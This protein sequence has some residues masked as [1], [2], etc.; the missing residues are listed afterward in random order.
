MIRVAAAVV[1]VLLAMAP[2]AE[3]CEAP[4]AEPGIVVAV[5]RGAATITGPGTVTGNVYRDDDPARL[6]EVRITGNGGEAHVRVGRLDREGI[7]MES[8]LGARRLAAEPHDVV[9]TF[10]FALLELDA[11]DVAEATTLARRVFGS[12]RTPFSERAAARVSAA[13]LAYR[14]AVPAPFMRGLG[15]EFVLGNLR[16]IRRGRTTLTRRLAVAPVTELDRRF[17]EPLLGSLRR[18]NRYLRRRQARAYDRGLRREERLRKRFGLSECEAVQMP[19][20]AAS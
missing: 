4:P 6:H 9:L 13:C 20:A 17:L 5:C 1:L 3:A 10:D 2:A 12:P 15:A 11:A 7:L 18:G 16:S 8:G 19:P 14:R